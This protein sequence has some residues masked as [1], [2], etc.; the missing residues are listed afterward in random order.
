M[1]TLMKRRKRNELLPFESNLLTPWSN[2]FLRPWSSRLFRNNFDEIN[3]LLR[4]EDVFKDDFFEDD[5]LMPAMNVKEH[6][7]DFEI[8]LAIP[9]FNKKDFE[10]SLEDDILHVCGKKEMEQEEK[11]DDFSR[12][13]FSYKSFKRSMMLPPSV[14]LNQDVKAS[15]KN[16]ILKVKL[17]KKEDVIEKEHPKKVIEVI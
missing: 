14:D 11:E 16:G 6:K 17:L 3:N 13:E 8:E 12:K 10:V 7:E 4:F 9:G 5:S 15:Y 2:N 1:T